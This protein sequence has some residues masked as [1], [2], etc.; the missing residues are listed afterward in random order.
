MFG[1]VIEP[2]RDLLLASQSNCLILLEKRNGGIV[3]L[4][5]ASVSCPEV[6]FCQ[7]SC[8]SCLR[9]LHAFLHPLAFVKTSF[10]LPWCS[11]EN[12]V[13]DFV[14]SFAITVF[15]AW[16]CSH[17]SNQTWNPACCLLGEGSYIM[18]KCSQMLNVHW[19]LIA[20]QCDLLHLVF[21]CFGGGSVKEYRGGFQCAPSDEKHTV[22]WCLRCRWHT[23]S[24]SAAG[25]ARGC[26]SSRRSLPY[27]MLS[28]CTLLM[29][30]ITQ[31]VSPL[32]GVP[33]NA[34]VLF[35]GP[36]L[37]F[38]L[39]QFWLQFQYKEAEWLSQQ[40]RQNP[41]KTHP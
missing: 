23:W 10:L 13:W 24:S 12:Q 29:W 28:G 7:D 22:T 6:Q 11:L 3:P 21:I 5:Q 14:S 41:R 36:F 30:W 33:Q 37:S 19:W 26:S 20:I 25:W 1:L 27:R 18:L 40:Q 16:L 31:K 17:C 8:L 4:F 2:K 35:T 38:E 9:Y 39:I 34:S 32:I 15:L